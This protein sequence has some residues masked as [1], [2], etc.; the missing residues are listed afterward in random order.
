MILRGLTEISFV[1]VMRYLSVRVFKNKTYVA[2]SR[3]IVG[4]AAY[5]LYR[6]RRHF[7]CCVT[8]CETYLLICWHGTCYLRG[9]SRK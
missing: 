8:V 3:K 9:A 4:V 6:E 2:F 5:C 7:V 1:G